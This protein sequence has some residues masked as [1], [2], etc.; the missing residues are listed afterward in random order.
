MSKNTR[1]FLNKLVRSENVTWTL[2][3][4]NQLRGAA[5]VKK[6]ETT[7]KIA[8]LIVKQSEEKYLI[9]VSID[10][11]KVIDSDDKTLD[12]FDIFSSFFTTKSA[13]AATETENLLSDLGDL[14]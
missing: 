6:D 13:A 14:L 10:G 3:G 5:S 8:V 4:T 9:T 1:H 11:T 7:K 2:V 12:I